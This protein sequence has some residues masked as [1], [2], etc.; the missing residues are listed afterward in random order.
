MSIKHIRSWVAALLI[1]TLGTP[2]GAQEQAGLSSDDAGLLQANE[3]LVPLF[4][5]PEISQPNVFWYEGTL[6]GLDQSPVDGAKIKI[7]LADLPSL[8]GRQFQ[9]ILNH[10]A[11]DELTM[12]DKAPDGLISMGPNGVSVL[13]GTRLEAYPF[14]TRDGVDCFAAT[15]LRAGACLSFVWV[16]DFGSPMLAYVHEG[17]A[18]AFAYTTGSGIQFAEAPETPAEPMAVEPDTGYDQPPQDF[19]FS[20]KVTQ[21]GFGDYSVRIWNEGQIIYVDYP[22]LNCGGTVTLLQQTDTAIEFEETLNRGTANC[23]SGGLITLSQISDFEWNYGW[24]ANGT[25][26]PSVEGAVTLQLPGKPPTTNQQ[27]A[28]EPDLS[29]APAVGT[30]LDPYDDL[31]LIVGPLVQ[32]IGPTSEVLSVRPDSPA[33]RS[34]IEVGDI[35]LIVDNG[36]GEPPAQKE[37]I[38]RA[39][40][41]SGSVEIHVRKPDGERVVVTIFAQTKALEAPT[42]APNDNNLDGVSEILTTGRF[43]SD[44]SALDQLS[45]FAAALGIQ[46]SD[47]SASIASGNFNPH[48][49]DLYTAYTELDGPDCEALFDQREAE[50]RA[51]DGISEETVLSLMKYARAY[52]NIN[53]RI[54]MLNIDKQRV[55]AW[56][57]RFGSRPN[58]LQTTRV[59]PTVV[60]YYAANE[61]TEEEYAQKRCD[62]TNAMANSISNLAVAIDCGDLRPS[63]T[64]NLIQRQL[65]L[66]QRDDVFGPVESVY[67]LRLRLLAD[68]SFEALDQLIVD[69]VNRASSELGPFAGLV[70]LVAPDVMENIKTAGVNARYA[71]LMSMYIMLRMDI[72]GDCGEPT[73][74]MSETTTV[75]VSYYNGLGHYRGSEAP[76]SYIDNF[77]VPTEFQS[78]LKTSGSNDVSRQAQRE[79]GPVVEALSCD[80]QIRR[81]LEQNMVA[82]F[83]NQPPAFVA[84]D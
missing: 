16:K 28:V 9:I 27:A 32:G 34:G 36:A 74:S 69:D 33:A 60:A 8:S 49:D 68:G 64:N 10:V 65:N 63:S 6:I 13:V 35:L 61:K 66:A 43:S 7:R 25:T 71:G 56:S 5:Y 40:E 45:L 46:D 76:Q 26:T 78:V 80:N 48:F 23:G 73:A 75:V 72:L 82:Y 84:V 67:A 53:C 12:P 14:S 22:E 83:N 17:K 11:S 44:N 55:D 39:L 1:A 2:T 20:G 81:N 3:E 54:F 24:S 50:L 47:I 30:F 79:L 57:T 21:R 42:I 38:N 58:I 59:D 4:P 15:P 62:F 51:G 19:E 70:T 77:R 29:E 52:P 37:M 31:E 41:R 18:V